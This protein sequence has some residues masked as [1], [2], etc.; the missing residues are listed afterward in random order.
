M[1]YLMFH[2]PKSGVLELVSLGR[3]PAERWF[4]CSAVLTVSTLADDV[5]MIVTLSTYGGGILV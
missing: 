3:A 4:K 1:I 2:L 5:T